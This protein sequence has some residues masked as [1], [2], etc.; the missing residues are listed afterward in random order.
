MAGRPRQS[1]CKRGHDLKWNAVYDELGY[2]KDCR[3]CIRVRAENRAIA[4]EI[5]R[6]EVLLEQAQRDLALIEEKPIEEREYYDW[7]A[8]KYLDLEKQRLLQEIYELQRG[9]E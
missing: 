2:R 7:N 3:G 4:K 6:V 5:A 9:Y 1:H 8:V